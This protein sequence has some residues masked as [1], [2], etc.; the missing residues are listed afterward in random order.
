MATR[1]LVVDDEQEFVDLLRYR[2]VERGYDIL[3]AGNGLKA[4]NMARVFLPDIIL[5]DILLPDLD[6]LSVCEILRHQPSTMKTPVILI[7]ALTGDVTQRLSK[8][9]ADD[10]FNKRVDFGR[11]DERITALLKLDADCSSDDA[12]EPPQ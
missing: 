9:Q 4:L 12:E 1:I 5:L 11:L 2:Y 6:G 8:V 3:T 10:F 7:S